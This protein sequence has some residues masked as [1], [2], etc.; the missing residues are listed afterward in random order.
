MTLQVRWDQT[1]STPWPTCAATVPVSKEDDRFPVPGVILQDNRQRWPYNA[2]VQSKQIII[3]SLVS[4]AEK[5][6]RRLSKAAAPLTEA[7]HMQQFQQQ[8]DSR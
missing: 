5:E 4:D 7:N 1:N 8:P 2:A 3:G 6:D